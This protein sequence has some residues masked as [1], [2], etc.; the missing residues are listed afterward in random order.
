MFR[1]VVILGLLLL[2]LPCAASDG[3]MRQLLNIG[4]NL[5]AARLKQ[6]GN[7]CTKAVIPKS[8]SMRVS[9][10]LATI[11]TV[12]LKDELGYSPAYYAAMVDD[13]AQLK[14]L[15]NLGYSASGPLGSLLNAAAY[16]NSVKAASLLLGRGLDP[17]ALNSSGSTPLLVAVGEGGPDVARLLLQHGARPSARDLRYALICKNQSVVDLLVQ[18]GAEIDAGARRLAN[19]YNLHLPPTGAN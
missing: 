12:G 3:R 2:S 18:S 9:Q 13:T 17:N 14:R 15:L 4:V 10:L 16:W 11:D 8:D 5:A 19:K 1:L 7:L 6:P